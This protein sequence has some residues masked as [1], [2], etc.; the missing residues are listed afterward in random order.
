M[1][2]E[3][4]ALCQRF[5]D[6]YATLASFRLFHRF[7]LS[8]SFFFLFFFFYSFASDLLDLLSTYSARATIVNYKKKGVKRVFNAKFVYMYIYA[9]GR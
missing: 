4:A 1:Q 2:Q 9:R 7:V 3:A 6:K 8:C 5:G